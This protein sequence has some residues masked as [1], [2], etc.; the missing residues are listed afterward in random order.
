MIMI[1]HLKWNVKPEEADLLP[2]SV[3]IPETEIN[4][5]RY[6]VGQLIDKISDYLWDKYGYKHDGFTYEVI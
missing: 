4:P 1:T 2:S 6:T 3:Y 5:N